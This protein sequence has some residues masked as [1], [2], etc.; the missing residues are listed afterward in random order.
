MYYKKRKK[1]GNT[2]RRKAKRSTRH[3][4]AIRLSSFSSH[5]LPHSSLTGVSLKSLLIFL[6]KQKTPIDAQTICDTLGI[7]PRSKHDIRSLLATLSHQHLLLPHGK[8][9][10]AINRETLKEGT[11]SV[12]FRGF[13]F[14]KL[15]N[16]NRGTSKKQQNDIFI[17]GRNLS[18]ALHGDKVLVF[19]QQYSSRGNRLEGAIL[20][21][22]ERPVSQ[23]VGVYTTNKNRSFVTPEDDHFPFQISIPPHYSGEAKNGYAVVVSLA[24]D[25]QDRSVDAPFQ[26]HITEVLGNPEDLGVQ[27]EMVIRKHGLSKE[28]SPEV[29]TEADRLTHGTEITSNRTDL[30]DIPHVTIDGETA[31]DFD[32]AVS[33]FKNDSGFRLYVSIA[34]VSHY[35][36][37]GSALDYEAYTRGTS[38]YFPTGVLPMLPERLSNDICSLKPNENRYT[39]TCILDFDHNGKVLKTK[40]CKSVICSQHRLTYTLVKKIL[41]DKDRESRNTYKSILPSLEWMEELARRLEIQRQKRGSI[42]LDIPETYVQLDNKEQAIVDIHKAERNQAHKIIEEF[43]LAANEAV[44]AFFIKNRFPAVFRVHDVPDP[45]KAI[46]LSRLMHYLGFQSTEDAGSLPWFQQLLHRFQGTPQEYIVN[47][48]T[49][50]VMQQAR[51]SPDNIGHFGLAAESYTH[52]TS[53]IRRYPD[54]MVHRALASMLKIEKEESQAPA[55]SLSEAADFLSG[56]ERAAVKAERDMLDRLKV[57]FL[58]DKIGE[59]F[60]GIISGISSYG[61]FVELQESLI[62]GAISLHDIPE[63]SFQIDE[64]NHRIIDRNSKALYQIGDIVQVRLLSVDKQRWRINFALHSNS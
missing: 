18:G 16:Q 39:F 12:N 17:P 60:D 44:A 46:E 36:K 23:I 4:K 9:K 22:L 37:P 47:N 43:M 11:L 1:R 24:E 5:Q 55:D 62:S 64:E 52:F 34:D 56:R 54:L 15:V 8:K 45:G 33:V 30:R 61:L 6:F 31:R 20:A 59:T 7:P 26:G 40:F 49:L 38:I 41:V 3:N 42:G 27:M 32:D 51:Y 10:Y 50:R 13:G 57:I 2:S 21:T 28:F 25:N 19:I 53:P 14:V 63:H 58:E 48:L 29:I 35:V